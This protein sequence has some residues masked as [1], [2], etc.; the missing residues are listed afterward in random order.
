MQQPY[1]QTKTELLL[2]EPFLNNRAMYIFCLEY[3]LT[4]QS[5]P[6][7]AN[8]ISIV[9]A[10]YYWPVLVIAG[11]SCRSH[12]AILNLNLFAALGTL[13]LLILLQ[14]AKSWTD[15]IY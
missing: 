1:E 7:S 12:L 9:C 15:P 14:W 11:I 3:A 5:T 10:F 2:V 4:N 6:S 13:R 8:F